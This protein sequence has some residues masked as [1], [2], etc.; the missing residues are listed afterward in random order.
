MVCVQVAEVC[1]LAVEVDDIGQINRIAYDS[2]GVHE[3]VGNFKTYDNHNLNILQSTA[4][5]AT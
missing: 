5:G 2:S 4:R 3:V 1:G